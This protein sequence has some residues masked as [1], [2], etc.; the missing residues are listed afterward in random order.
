MLPQENQ[1]LFHEITGLDDFDALQFEEQR[2]Q[3]FQ[4]TEAI[5]EAALDASWDAVLG[6]QPTESQWHDPIY[7]ASYLEAIAQKYDEKF[8]VCE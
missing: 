6:E 4:Q 8:G 1:A 7:R 3:I 5:P 2:Y